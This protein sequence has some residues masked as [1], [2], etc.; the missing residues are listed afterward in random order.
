M[1]M[2]D[3]RLKTPEEF[4]A[5]LDARRIAR[6]AALWEE[7][8]GTRFRWRDLFGWLAVFGLFGAVVVREG[9]IAF[10]LAASLLLMLRLVLNRIQ[11]QQT[12]MLRLL[13]ELET[14][15]AQHRPPFVNPPDA[16]Q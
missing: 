9:A 4:G 12:A 5:S 11:R 6:R 15:E 1:Y 3:Q 13:E 16:E 14:D 8:R 2:E 10:M 7:A